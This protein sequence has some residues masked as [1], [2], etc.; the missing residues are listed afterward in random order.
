MGI[1]ILLQV[2][3]LTDVQS[4]DECTQ[5]DIKRVVLILESCC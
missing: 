3:Y 4:G 1:N 2:I 5:Q